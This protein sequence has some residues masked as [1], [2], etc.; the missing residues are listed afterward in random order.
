MDNQ[1]QVTSIRVE[2]TADGWCVI[3]RHNGEDEFRQE[4]LVKSDAESWAEG[5]RI[6]MG[7]FVTHS[8]LSAS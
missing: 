2:R 4:F 1:L 5:Q 6:L 7:N 3:K 8:P